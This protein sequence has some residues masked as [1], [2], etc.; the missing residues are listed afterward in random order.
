MHR[1]PTA[2]CC[3]T[4]GCYPLPR[5]D[6]TLD[7]LSGAKWFSTLDMASGYWQV[8]L[9]DQQAKQKSAFIAPTVGYMRAVSCP[10]GYAT[11][12]RRL[13]GSWTV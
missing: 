2:E 10:L 4:E 9:D 12:R 3:Y 5:I 6:D 8:Q 13:R 1:L 7:A 11:L